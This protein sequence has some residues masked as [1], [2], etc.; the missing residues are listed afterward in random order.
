MSVLL[1]FLDGVGL[2]DVDP[3]HNPWVAARTPTLHRLLGQ[4]LAGQ[5]R[6][7]HNGALL[8]PTDATLGVAGLPQSATGQTALLTGLNA[9]SLVGR[10]VTAYPTTELRAL[11]AS[12]G[13]F[14][15]LAAAGRSSALANAYTPEYHAAVAARRLRHAAITTAAKSAGV[16]L[17]TVDDLQRGEAVFHDL[18]NA[19]PR[20][21]GHDVPVLTPAEAGENLARLAGTYDFTLFEF[22]LTDLVAHGRVEMDPA[23]IVEMLDGFLAGILEARPDHLTVVLTS[24]HGNTEDS[25]SRLHTRNPVPTLVTGPAQAQFRDV[26]AITDVA[27]AILRSVG[28]EG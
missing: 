6:V 24:D 14:A 5:A 4:P 2:G 22:F 13:I 28:V 16:R 17:R 23:A 7:E 3:A 11:L 12:H 15:R 25:R 21:W 27:P 19:R 10:H 18:T 20:A 1:V 26:G 9:P 8:I